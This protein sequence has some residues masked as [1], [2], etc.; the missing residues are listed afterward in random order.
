ME[1]EVQQQDTERLRHFCRFSSA[2]TCGVD[3]LVAPL[4][5]STAGRILGRCAVV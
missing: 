1:E 5:G 4:F 2:K 3:L